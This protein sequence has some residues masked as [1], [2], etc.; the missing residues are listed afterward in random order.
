MVRQSHHSFSLFQQ[1]INELWDSV[2][3]WMYDPPAVMNM[4]PGC[5]LP[6]SCLMKE[7]TDFTAPR[8]VSHT[9]TII[10]TTEQ[11]MAFNFTQKFTFACWDPVWIDLSFN[12]ANANTYGSRLVLSLHDL[13]GRYITHSKKYNTQINVL[14]YEIKLDLWIFTQFTEPSPSIICILSWNDLIPLWSPRQEEI[15]TKYSH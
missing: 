14:C 12:Y 3:I 7:K 5:S 9:P 8:T 1:P 11:L 10:T 4:T 13:G 15:H 6:R 2:S